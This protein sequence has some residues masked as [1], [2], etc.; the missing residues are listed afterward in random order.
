VALGS[1]GR[2]PRRRIDLRVNQVWSEKHDRPG[3][4]VTDTRPRGIMAGYPV[5]HAADRVN[6]RAGG[7]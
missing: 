3:P 2:H 7:R 6:E 4:G 1:R 5:L